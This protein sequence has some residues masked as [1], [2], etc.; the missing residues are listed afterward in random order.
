MD[1]VSTRIRNTKTVI[2]PSSY[3]ILCIVFIYYMQ[4]RYPNLE[5]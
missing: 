2:P 4:V 3:I 5:I 1:L